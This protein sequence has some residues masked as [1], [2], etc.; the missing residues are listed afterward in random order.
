MHWPP[1]QL[2][3]AFHNRQ[4]I[5]DAERKL[6]AFLA[7]TASRRHALGFAVVASGADHKDPGC[8]SDR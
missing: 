6:A 2:L 3:W 8:G 5:V 1:E 7:D 4:V